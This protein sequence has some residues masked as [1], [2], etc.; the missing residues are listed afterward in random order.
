AGSMQLDTIGVER[1][2]FCRVDSDCWDV[3]LKFFDPE[4]DRRAKKILRYT[5]DV[6]DIMPVTMGQPRIWDAL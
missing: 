3:K 5:I 2:P 4:N 1:S 6:S